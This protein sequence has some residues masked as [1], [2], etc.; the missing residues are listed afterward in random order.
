[1]AG[2][3]MVEVVAVMPHA[4]VP[5][6]ATWLTE[7]Q[8]ASGGIL[9]Q[10]EDGSLALQNPAAAPSLVRQSFLTAPSLHSRAHP[11]SLSAVM[12]SHS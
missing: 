6:K 12:M 11:P 2:A 4:P 8:A 9:K 5:A 7:E 10:L 1:M 3:A